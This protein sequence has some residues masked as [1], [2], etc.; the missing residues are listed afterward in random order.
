MQP[1]T[2]PGVFT[3]TM[4]PMPKPMVIE[5]EACLPWDSLDMRGATVSAIRLGV[6]SKARSEYEKA[7]GAFKKKRLPEAEQHVRGAIEK[8]SNYQAAQVM[9]GEILQDEQKMSDAR[10][11][12]EHALTLDPT[13]LPPYLCLAGLLEHENH[14]GELLTMSRHFLGMNPVGD[15]YSYYYSAVAHFHLYDLQEAQKNASQAIAID[16]EHHQ[17]GLY[18]LLAQIY[19]AQGDVADAAIQIRQFLKYNNVRQDKDAAKEYLAKLQSQ[20]AAK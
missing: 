8:Y 11:A 2:L 14:W 17:P 15:R 6:P 10:D 20:Q 19:G 13:Y 16:T 4:E 12:C 9:L 18:F 7:C 1:N 5:D 3:P